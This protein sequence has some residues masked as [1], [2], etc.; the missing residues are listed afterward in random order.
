MAG[1]GADVKQTARLEATNRVA[2]MVANLVKAATTVEVNLTIEALKDQGVL[3]A[4]P[5]P[6]L[7]SRCGHALREGAPFCPEC[8]SVPG[9]E[10]NNAESDPDQEIVIDEETPV[11][12]GDDLYFEEIHAD[13]ELPECLRDALL[14]LG[15]DWDDAV[16]TGLSLASAWQAE[17]PGSEASY[18]Q[19]IDQLDP[20]VKQRLA[21][22][23]AGQVLLKACNDCIL[24]GR[25]RGLD[26]PGKSRDMTELRIFES[27][28]EWQ[29]EVFDPLQHLDNF[30]V[31]RRIRVG[32]KHLT[33]AQIQDQLQKRRARLPKLGE[34]LIYYR[35][36]FFD[37]ENL[38]SAYAKLAEKGLEQK[39]VAEAAG[40]PQ[41]TLARWC[42]PDD[43]IWVDTPHG[44]LALRQF[45][46]RNARAAKGRDLRQA[47]ILGALVAARAE[48][49]QDASSA[50]LWQWLAEQGLA[51][52]MKDRT[53]R[54]YVKQ[55]RIMESIVEALTEIPASEQN[56]AEAV[57]EKLVHMGSELSIEEIRRFL[58]YHRIYREYES[59][60][61]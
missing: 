21:D 41:S 17:C 59:N 33:F 40:I 27:D 7:C 4:D 32:L 36:D 60:A 39:K 9:D 48:L 29:V 58:T 12:G 34:A 54:H 3:Q 31:H 28:G 50:D 42:N 46:G 55:A 26:E 45:F 13:P 44:V 6:L 14:A 20:A 8:G 10:E 37:A 53:K 16:E 19:S 22:P 56:I 61:D 25:N 43:G 52:E 2:N 38:D 1:I 30:D 51:F 47:V 15:W 11:Q 57:Q 23:L 5:G 24:S 35:R 49:G 18:L